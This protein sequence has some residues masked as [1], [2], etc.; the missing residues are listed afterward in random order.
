[1]ASIDSVEVNTFVSDLSGT[2]NKTWIGG[3][4]VA[5]E[6]T[7]TWSDGSTWSYLNWKTLQP[8]NGGTSGTAQNCV[9]MNTDGAWDDVDCTSTR[10]YMCAKPANGQTALT[11]NPACSCEAGWS[12]YLDTG[13]CYTRMEELTTGVT[14]AVAGTNCEAAGAKLASITSVL[15]NKCK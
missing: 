7:W 12:G 4:D 6:D 10:Q 11:S 13:K 5:T 9:S 3:T 8:N 15:E 14:W 2:V 1:M